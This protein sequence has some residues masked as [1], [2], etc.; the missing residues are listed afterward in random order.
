MNQHT[1]EAGPAQGDRQRVEAE[2]DQ[3]GFPGVIR[4]IKRLSAE[5]GQGRRAW[6]RPELFAYLIGGLSAAVVGVTADVWMLSGTGLVFILLAVFDPFARVDREANAQRAPIVA[7]DDR[8]VVTDGHSVDPD[9]EIP[10]DSTRSHPKER[11]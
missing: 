6:N 10:A 7:T 5:A 3:H 2:A 4:E 11:P 9:V 1:P 8:P